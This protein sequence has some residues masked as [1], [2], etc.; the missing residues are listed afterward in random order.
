MRASVDRAVE[1][2]PIAAASPVDKPV[3]IRLIIPV[4]VDAHRVHKTL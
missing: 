2:R 1:N 4:E 3:Y